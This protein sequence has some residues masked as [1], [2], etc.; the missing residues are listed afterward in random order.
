MWWFIRGGGQSDADDQGTITSLPNTADTQTVVLK[1][2]KGKGHEEGALSSSLIDHSKGQQLALKKGDGRVGFFDTD[3]IDCIVAR[4]AKEMSV[5]A[6]IM[7]QKQHQQQQEKGVLRFYDYEGDR[8]YKQWLEDQ[9]HVR[10][11]LKIHWLDMVIDRPLLCLTYLVR[12]GTTVGLFHGVGRS[13]YL[14][15]TMDKMYAKLYGVSLANIA[16]YEVSLSVIKGAVVAAAGTVGVIVGESAINITT[17]IFKGDVSVPERTWANIWV[18]GTLCGLSS[19]GAF[20]ALHA[21]LLTPWGTTAALTGFTV[22]G[23]LVG[24]AL[25]R[26]T[27]HPFASERHGRIY[28]P[29]WRPWYERRLKDG[30][31]AH[32]RGKYT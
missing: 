24:L 19:G 13:L 28:E 21:T 12:L 14:Y 17:T 7:K 11:T 10:E 2:T 30:G 20:S 18:C 31:A 9:K 27:Y 23:S 6:E 5:A 16:L 22:L 25:A 3:A 15:R 4:Y 8:R 1:Q 32:M 29:Y 26:F